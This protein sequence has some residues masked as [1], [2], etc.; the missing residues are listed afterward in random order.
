MNFIG[1]SMCCRFVYFIFISALLAGCNTVEVKGANEVELLAQ[2]QL[3]CDKAISNNYYD[4]ACAEYTKLSAHEPHV[5]DPKIRKIRDGYIDY[6]MQLEEIEKTKIQLDKS[7]KEAEKIRQYQIICEEAI[8]N[9]LYDKA[10]DEY[11]R[12]TRYK[13]YSDDDN[14]TKIRDKI[15]EYRV[16]RNNTKSYSTATVSKMN[17]TQLCSHF[18]EGVTSRVLTGNTQ[19]DKNIVTELN[20]RGFHTN[21]INQARSGNI[22]IGIPT[23]MMYATIGKPDKENKTVNKSGVR[24]QNVYRSKDL[25]VYTKNGIITSWQDHSK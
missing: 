19:F 2:Y 7:K 6:R 23:C 5:Y 1:D 11:T 8:V 14:I 25:Y 21:Q 16:N 24:I 13:P 9:K 15:V 12:I 4:K 10:C 22:A 20:K 3:V 18:H 17:N